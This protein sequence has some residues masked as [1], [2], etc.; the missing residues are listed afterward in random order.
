MRG[1]AKLA[2]AHLRTATHEPFDHRAACCIFGVLQHRLITLVAPAPALRN[3]GGDGGAAGAGAGGGA[4]G[5][6]ECKWA[7]LLQQRAHKG[8]GRLPRTARPEASVQHADVAARYVRQHVRQLQGLAH[9]HADQHGL[10]Y[11]ELNHHDHNHA[12][13]YGHFVG[14]IYRNKHGNQQRYV[15]RDFVRQHIQCRE[16]LPAGGTGQQKENSARTSSG[17]RVR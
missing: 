15:Y 2:R 16:A 6:A 13:V 3:G 12:D 7:R 9:H 14:D 17:G 5:G 10:I 4:G 1:R 11:A 8:P